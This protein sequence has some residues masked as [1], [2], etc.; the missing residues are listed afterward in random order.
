MGWTLG[1]VAFLLL[2]VGLIYVFYLRILIV[3]SS[4]VSVLFGSAWIVALGT[5]FFA[6]PFEYAG[7][8]LVERTG[9]PA[10]LHELD[11]RIEAIEQLPQTVW[12]RLKSPFG[13]RAQEV[14]GP[15]PLPQAGALEGALVPAF[16]VSVSALLRGVAFA[17]SA[18]IMLVAL[19]LRSATA[20]VGEL[21]A[22]RRRVADLEG[23]LAKQEESGA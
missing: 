8:V 20:A 16:E 6:A 18:L 17:L 2:C 5:L 14:A 9:L 21:Q 11:E 22:L 7:G 19:S 12:D 10:F 3:A 13:P 23:A 1:V 4:G 15:E